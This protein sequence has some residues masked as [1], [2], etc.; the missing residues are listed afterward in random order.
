MCNLLHDNSKSIKES[1]IGYKVCSVFKGKSP[2]S[3]MHDCIKF[4]R[5]KRHDWDTAYEGDGF[6]FFLNKKEAE[7]LSKMWD[8]ESNSNDKRKT[9]VFEIK[10][11]GGLGTHLERNIIEGDPFMIALCKSFQI[12]RRV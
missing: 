3:I 4:R 5:G 9:A 8:D 1:G 6:C 2:S 10:Y 11:W 12:I 7:R